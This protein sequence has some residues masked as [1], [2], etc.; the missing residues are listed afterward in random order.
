MTP[1]AAPNSAAARDIAYALHPY[2]DHRAHAQNG[3]MII[4]S[5]RGVR[6]TD[7]AGREYLETVAG[8]W[9]ASLGF[10]NERLVEAATAQMRKLPFYHGFTSRSH[11]PLIELSEMLIQRA[12]VPMSKVFFAN[13]GSEA[14][15]TA[16]KM[17]WYFNNAEGQQEIVVQARVNAS[18][19]LQ[20]KIHM[21]STVVKAL[22]AEF[23]AETLGAAMKKFAADNGDKSMAERNIV[24]A[25]ARLKVAQ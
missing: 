10:S 20:E 25:M 2:T 21:T 14:N 24:A 17:I 9:C 4:T 16:I 1:P 18:L 23:G 19:A 5:G 13:S 3:P 8:L 12:P 11:E 6:V 7:D 15:D 22:E